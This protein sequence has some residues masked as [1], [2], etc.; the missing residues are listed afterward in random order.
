MFVD[1][2]SS[3]YDIAG[4]N[5]VVSGRGFTKHYSI[6]DDLHGTNIRYRVL[7]SSFHVLQVGDL[8]AQMSLQGREGMASSRCIKCN[9]TQTEWTRGITGSPITKIDLNHTLHN[10]Y[11]GQ[12]HLVLW[13][14]C[15]SDTVVPL[16]H[17]ELGTVNDQLFKKLFRD[18]LSLDVAANNEE[19]KEIISV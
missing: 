1:K 3:R 5:L 19:K 2:K 14:L 8:A 13:N 4:R 7:I 11:I 10:T 12:K 6:D 17:C 15:A 16:L 18:I 9:L